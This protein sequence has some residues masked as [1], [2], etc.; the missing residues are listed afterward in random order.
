MKLSSLVHPK[1][2]KC[3][4][5]AQTKDQAL[6]E[7]VEVL[8]AHEPSLGAEEI[9]QSLAERERLG[10]FSMGKGA[11]FPHARTEKVKDFTV[12]I[13]TSP[14]GIEFKAP[15]GLK[16]RVIVLFV[17]PKK[18]SNLY[19]HALA[20]FLSIFANES[21]ASRV[22]HAQNGDELVGA[23][24][25]ASGRKESSVRDT[26]GGPV[27]SVT[28]QT[29]LLRTVEVMLQNRVDVL[30]VVD[31]E[32]NLVGETSAS[33][34]LALGVKEHLQ[35][36]SNAMVLKSTEPFEGMLRAHGEA[37]IEALPGLVAPNSFKTVQEDDPLLEV[38]V[39]LT[40]AGARS[41][42]VLKGRRLTGVLTL[43]DLLRRVAGKS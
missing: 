16:I 18:H 13:G 37:A 6:R 1:L 31:G 3:G 39:R 36:L 10:P 20:Q 38:A 42:Y 4:I 34:I 8:T 7:L 25:A 15:D 9:L 40:R 28:P 2:V 23:L 22:I 26:I 27:L 41:A 30:P 14:Q 17:I 33:A 43:T 24:D 12:V 32:G 11:A 29:T 21:L 5:S 35:N 19:L